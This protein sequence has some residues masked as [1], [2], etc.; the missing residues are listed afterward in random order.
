MSGGVRGSGF[1]G[2]GSRFGALCS[3]SDVGCWRPCFSYTANSW[4]SA[5]LRRVK[6]SSQKGP[7][8]YGTSMEILWNSYG[9]PMVH[10]ARSTRPTRWQPAINTLKL[11]SREACPPALRKHRPYSDAGCPTLDRNRQRQQRLARARALPAADRAPVRPQSLPRSLP[12]CPHCGWA[13][14]FLVR[15]VP[16]LRLQPAPALADSS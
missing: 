4:R 10:Q 2:R 11:R 3:R 6:P 13:A 12:L 9:L 15:S 1:E 5:Q 8:S 16:P 7:E 14:L